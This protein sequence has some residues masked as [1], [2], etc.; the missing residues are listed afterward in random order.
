MEIQSYLINSCGQV[1]EKNE[2]NFYFFGRTADRKSKTVCLKNLS[3]DTE[4]HRMF[5]VFDGAGGMKNGQ[6]ASEIAAEILRK[7]VQDIIS[8]RCSFGEKLTNICHKINGEICRELGSCSGTT[9]VMI[10]LYE[11]SYF[12]CNI[13]DSCAF[14]MRSGKL[15]LLTVE[16]TEKVN[17]S[18][19]V[20]FKSEVGKKYPLTQYLGIPNEEMVIEPH[21]KSGAIKAGDIFLLCSDG[22]TN[23]ADNCVLSNILGDTS[24][25][26]NKMG[27]LFST[28]YKNSKDNITIL[29]IK[30]LK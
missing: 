19:T 5:A 1:R 2:D 25:L 13:G 9:A 8:D 18:H 26:E 24:G 17:L 22:L 12:L 3:A 30:V 23:A 29:C 21:I 10:I 11:N 14:L 4:K 15:D 27:A 28:A 16:D 6:R 20:G 7:S